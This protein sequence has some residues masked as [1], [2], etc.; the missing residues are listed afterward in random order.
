MNV[1]LTSTVSYLILFGSN[2]SLSQIDCIDKYILHA[3]RLD[4]D[5]KK[6]V[7]QLILWLNKFPNAILQW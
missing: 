6:Y 2:W 3:S 1:V 7:F 4:V 5:S